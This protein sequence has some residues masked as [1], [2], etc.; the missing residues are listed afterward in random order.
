MLTMIRHH[1]DTYAYEPLTR[2]WSTPRLDYEQAPAHE[3]LD[4][5]T[6]VAAASVRT[7][8]ITGLAAGILHHIPILNHANQ[9]VVHLT[10]PG[11]QQPPP[12][13]QWENSILRYRYAVLPDTDICLIGGNRVTT[14]A[15]TFTDICTI[16]GELEGLAFLEAA[17]HMGHS[18][19]EFQA[20][21]D[22]NDH[23][24]GMARAQKV[25]EQALYGIES[26]YETYARY[27]ITTMLP[28]LQVD[29]QAIIPIPSRWYYDGFSRRRVDLL[30][31]RFIIIEIDGRDKI[32]AKPRQT[33]RGA[34]RPG[35]SRKAPDSPRLPRAEI[36]PLGTQNPFDPHPHPNPGYVALR[37]RA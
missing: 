11:R 29:P 4:L 19:Q 23:R 12:R 27:I 24:W 16:N 31:E 2:R 20:Y 36:R 3:K 15:R 1:D 28:A 30:I 10:L 22:R 18:K 5:H 14:L 17:L 35:V 34:L 32:P 33:H 26:V 6:R 8:V 25:L 21:I 37:P 13:S 7:A 9:V